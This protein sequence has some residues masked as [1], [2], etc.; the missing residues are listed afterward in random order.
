MT[1]RRRSALLATTIVASFL[2]APALAVPPEPLVVTKMSDPDPN[3]VP[4]KV[5]PPR[6]R[7]SLRNSDEHPTLDQA[8]ENLGR[9]TGQ[10]AKVGAQQA[11]SNPQWEEEARER[12][13]KMRE[14]A[15]APRN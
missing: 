13:R 9:I 5:E 6:A 11:R 14:Q 2:T 1:A 7:H 12:L 8:M 4:P 10:L 15:G 3:Y